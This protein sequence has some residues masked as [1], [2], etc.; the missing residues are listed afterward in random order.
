MATAMPYGRS[1]D[2]LP[3]GFQPR[4]DNFSTMLFV[5]A[6]FHGVLILGVSFTAGEPAGSES[7]AASV[8]VVL[9]TRE[10]EKRLE[11]SDAEYIAR[12][13]LT[14]SGNTTEE[15]ELP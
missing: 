4:S 13:N 8:E 3:P 1:A 11:N 9:L 15:E 12:Q 14:G 7:D 5:A 10:Y 2:R 6:L